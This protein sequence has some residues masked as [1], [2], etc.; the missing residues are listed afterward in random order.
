PPSFRTS[1]RCRL[2]ADTV[3]KRVCRKQACWCG[4]GFTWSWPEVAAV[5]RTS[6]LDWPF[7]QSTRTPDLLAGRADAAPSFL[8]SARWRRGE[9]V[10]SAG[11]TSEPHPL[12][13]VMD[14]EMSKAHLNALAFIPRFEEALCSH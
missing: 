5:R 8:G 2:L 10:T 7:T 9:L 3:E 11:E 6:R 1:G 4:G 14:L 13:T 12:E